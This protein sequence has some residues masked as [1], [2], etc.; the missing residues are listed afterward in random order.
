M[1]SNAFATQSL[2]KLLFLFLLTAFATG[3]SA[4][5]R[6]SVQGLVKKSDGTALEDKNYDLTFRFYNAETG[7]AAIASET[8]TT[9]I[10]GGVYSAILG[11]G[12]GLDMLPFDV[13][14]Y[15]SVAVDG[16]TELLPRIAL[17][18]APYAISLQGANNK[19]PSIGTVKADALDV[20]GAVNASGAVS[21]GSLNATGNATLSGTTNTKTQ[22]A[23]GRIYSNDGFGYHN[24][25]TGVGTGLFFD[26][27][28][29]KA[30]IYT[31][32]NVRFHAWDDNKNYYRASAGHIFDIGDVNVT[33]KVN[34]GTGIQNYAAL[35]VSSTSAYL[36]GQNYINP[37]TL[38]GGEGLFTGEQLAIYSTGDVAAPVFISFS[39]ARIKN[40]IGQS[41]RKN[42]LN[43]LNKIKITDYTFVD[44]IANG[45]RVSKKVIAQEL[46][47]L[48]PQAVSMITGVVPDIYQPATITDGRVVLKNNLKPGE[49]VQLNFGGERQI[50]Q[51]LSANATEFH[52]PV[53][54]D[55]DVFVYGREVNDFHV[56]DYEALSTLNISATQELTQKV[57][58]L[59]A[60]VAALTAEKNALRTENTSFR[61]D[62]QNQQADF[63]KQLDELSRRLKSLETAASNR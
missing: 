37:P 55:G 36:G 29:K 46:R 3:L 25:G 40:V 10:N 21:A 11:G 53:K 8:V 24:S 19:F 27:S 52:V 59:E 12:G 56:V 14:Y 1:K 60:E 35:T 5:V 45:N 42:D 20:A 49:R 43:T 41:D 2:I 17:S 9:E 16:G 7:G 48:Y 63:G 13:P 22:F 18:A 54:K 6:L 62:M 33:G 39:D 61:A 51:V 32:G 58:R 47:Q 57:E 34:I 38:P 31:E 4:Q 50:V 23:D 26:G 44:K 15:V 30:S 28:S